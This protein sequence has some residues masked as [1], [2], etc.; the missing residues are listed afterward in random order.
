VTDQRIAP[1]DQTAWYRRYWEGVGAKF[2][3]AGLVGLYV[4]TTAAIVT[5]VWI[6][7]WIE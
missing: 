6:L 4:V 3:V 2:L 5:A 1:E 7:D